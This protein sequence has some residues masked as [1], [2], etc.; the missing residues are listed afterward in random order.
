MKEENKYKLENDNEAI[1]IGTNGTAFLPRINAIVAPNVNSK[2]I[3][4]DPANKPAEFDFKGKKY[5][6]IVYWGENND[7]PNQILTKVGNCEVLS[8]GLYFNAWTGY[9]SGIIPCYYDYNS[10][11]NKIVKHYYYKGIELKENIRA[12]ELEEIELEETKGNIAKKKLEYVKKDLVELRK[13]YKTWQDTKQQLIEFLAEND[14]NHL[15]D[16]QLIDLNYFFMA[17]PL[18]ILNRN[19]KIVQIKHREAAFSRWEAKDE[20]GKVNHLFYSHKFD[21]QPI[22]DEEYMLVYSS[23]DANNPLRDLKEK[24]G[25]IRDKKGKISHANIYEYIIPLPLPSPSR[26]YYPKSPYYSVF[27]SGWYDLWT[28]VPKGKNSI[29][30]N[31]M[32]ISY[33]IELSDDYFKGIFEEEGITEK[34]AMKTRIK[35][36]YKKLNDF[37]AGN[38]NFGKA[39]VSFVTYTHD[40]KE[41][42]K[43]KI[44][45]IE[46]PIKG[47]EYIEDSEEASNM[48]SQ[49]MWVHPS[50]IGASP[51]KN[52]NINGTEAREL[53]IIKN[54]MQVPFRDRVVKPFYIAKYINGWD[55]SLEWLIPN[56]ELTTLDEN[57]GAKEVVN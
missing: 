39:V 29:F 14:V 42:R 37:L 25:L 57:K 49:A 51:G 10:N 2:D 32:N 43:M 55:E 46:H 36:E 28:K 22:P 35:A 54:A 45:P 26:F 53:F 20:N 5:K 23:L 16:E 24:L 52:K 41:R 17:V 11:G 50:I 3:F 15:I 30:D 56:I 8:A 48:M 6:G 40:G 47:G 33:Q 31:I 1:I 4:E 21:E 34:E 9:G 19:N 12:L 44:I 18:I 7:L 27:L 38:E 13:Q